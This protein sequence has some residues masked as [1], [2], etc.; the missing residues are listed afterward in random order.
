MISM[1]YDPANLP[2]QS[3]LKPLTE[4]TATCARSPV[5]AG[6]LERQHFA[7]AC[8][9]LWLDGELVHLEDLVPPRRHPIFA[10]R[11]TN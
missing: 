2:I 1:R 11:H 7:D 8:A 6:F 5:G 10:L 9:S 4:A 3:L